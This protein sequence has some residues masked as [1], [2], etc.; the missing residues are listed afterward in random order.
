MVMKMMIVTP[1]MVACY[2]HARAQLLKLNTMRQSRL[3][4]MEFHN[5]HDM[6]NILLVCGGECITFTPVYDKVAKS[7]LNY[8]LGGLFVSQMP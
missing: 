2:T 5:H 6:N 7:S 3:S 1:R 8:V 4:V